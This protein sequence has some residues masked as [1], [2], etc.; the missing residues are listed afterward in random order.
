MV[1]YTIVNRN[2]ESKDMETPKLKR[3]VEKSDSVSWVVDLEDSAETMMNRLVRRTHSLRTIQSATLSPC[4][5][6]TRT[7]PNPH[8]RQ[9]RRT[10]CVS[11]LNNEPQR[12]RSFSF[13]S[14]TSEVPRKLAAEWDRSFSPSRYSP[15]PQSQMT[16]SNVDEMEDLIVVETVGED[17]LT[18]F[19]L[20]QQVEKGNLKIM[21]EDF[22]SPNLSLTSGDSDLT[23]RRI[24]DQSSVDSEDI[25]MLNRVDGLSFS[26]P[27]ESAGEA[28]I[29]EETSDNDSGA[30]DSEE[31]G[32]I[33]CSDL[34]SLSGS[35]SELETK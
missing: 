3:V 13:D 25:F 4:H 21:A 17:P 23:I 22:G 9:R 28:M 11:C 5:N 20:E 19:R 32:E 34:E 35:V 1:M 27:K 33:Y 7:L 16:G 29:S 15:S 30:R 31:E 24:N 26:L 18:F 6:T 2:G 8:K 10:T 14:D 12:V